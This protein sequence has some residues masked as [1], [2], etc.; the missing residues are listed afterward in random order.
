MMHTYGTVSVDKLD[1]KFNEVFEATAD[2]E[3]FVTKQ[4]YT[5]SEPGLS[6]KYRYVYE[7][8]YMAGYEDK[9]T[10]TVCTCLF[11]VMEPKSLCKSRRDLM[12]KAAGDKAT[13]DDLTVLDVMDYAETGSVLVAK[14]TTT[15]KEADLT[16]EV[17]TNV[18]PG[19]DGLRGFYL[20]NYQNLIGTR[21]WDVIK[22][23]KGKIKDAL[24]FSLKRSLAK[25]KK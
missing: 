11:M 8:V 2:E 18:L 19:Y 16:R 20:D 6:F 4:V 15:E 17:V 23:A 22:E 12:L 7:E 21:G 9:P 3:K 10:D 25:V 24:R 13:L 5:H 1:K 14:K